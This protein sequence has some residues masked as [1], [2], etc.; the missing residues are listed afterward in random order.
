MIRIMDSDEMKKQTLKWVDTVQRDKLNGNDHKIW[1]TKIHT[2]T[3][4]INR[5]VYAY[6]YVKIE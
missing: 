3:P 4:F 1:Y 6:R 2:K 5:Y